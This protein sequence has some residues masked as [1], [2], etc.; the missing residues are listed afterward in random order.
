MIVHDE[1]V[2]QEDFK[3]MLKPSSHIEISLWSDHMSS[4]LWKLE[5]ILDLM[6]LVC[7]VQDLKCE[8]KL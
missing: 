8:K 5:G 6:A 4:F 2:V 7:I 1:C 3:N